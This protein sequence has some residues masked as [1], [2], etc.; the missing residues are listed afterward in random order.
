MLYDFVIL[1]PGNSYTL[2]VSEDR[3]ESTVNA[4]IATLKT[5]GHIFQIKGENRETQIR[6][7]SIYGWYYKPHEK[8]VQEKLLDGMN[9]VIEPPE[10]DWKK[11]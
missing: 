1:M 6:G 4:I 10:D 2:C 7:E 11:E 8:T 3:L 5:P 9:K